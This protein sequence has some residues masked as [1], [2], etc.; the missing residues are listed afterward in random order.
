LLLSNKLIVLVKYVQ[1]LE[2]LMQ[3]LLAKNSNNFTLKNLRFLPV[4]EY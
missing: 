1:V 4:T 3:I 2:I